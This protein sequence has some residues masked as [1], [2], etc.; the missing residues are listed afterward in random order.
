MP[1]AKCAQALPPLPAVPKTLT[2][3]I[4]DAKI[5]LQAPKPP[6]QLTFAKIECLTNYYELKLGNRCTAAYFYTVK[7]AKLEKASAKPRKS[8]PAAPRKERK[9]GMKL[10]RKIFSKL[11]RESCGDQLLAY[12]GRQRACGLKRIQ[13]DALK[14]IIDY[15]EDKW[16]LELA[17]EKVVPLNALKPGREFGLSDDLEESLLS[18]AVMM[19]HMPSLQYTPL[20]RGFYGLPGENPIPI[21]G[22]FELWA[23]YK[24]HVIP[25]SD[26]LYL[27]VNYAITAF[28]KEGELIKLLPEL[29]QQNGVPPTLSP[30]DVNDLKKKLTRCKARTTHLDRPKTFSITG[31]TNKSAAEIRFTDRE[32]RDTSV[33]QY[34]AKKY[35]K[36]RYP[37]LP[38]I[39]CG[40]DNPKFF[41]IEVIKIEKGNP[42]RGE[43]TP[44]LVS[45][46][47]KLAAI[48][49][50][51]RLEEIRAKVGK[52]RAQNELEGEFDMKVDAELQVPAR[53]LPTP[54]LMIADGRGGSKEVRVTP[55]VI[56]F[57]S[58][59]FF[60]GSKIQKWT[61]VIT[62]ERVHQRDVG[63]FAQIFRDQGAASGVELGPP[64]MKAQNQFHVIS[65]RT[66]FDIVEKSIESFV[67]QNKLEFVLFVISD[68]SPIHAAIKFTCDVKLGVSSK[69]VKTNTVRKVVTND[70][71]G[72][73]Q[74]LLNILYGLNPKFNG[75]NVVG[76]PTEFAQKLLGSC[77]IL[78]VGIDV[79]H[80]QA[81]IREGHA[82]M[83]S[84][85]GIV[86]T[87]NMNGTLYN[88]LMRAQRKPP[89]SADKEIV[90]ADILKPALRLI[91]K[92]FYANTKRKPE[93]I[94][95]YRDGV[96]T[97][98]FQAVLNKEMRAI[99][100]VCRDLQF[101]PPI[102]FITVQ[103]R[104][105]TRLFPKKVIVDNRNREKQNPIAGTVVDSVMTGN[106]V[107]N[108]FMASHEGIQGTSKPAHYTVLADE[109][110]FSNDQLQ[111]LTYYLC[112]LYG[113]CPRAV[114][115]PSPVY[116]AHHVAF[117]AAELGA[118]K[119]HSGNLSETAT[120]SSGSSGARHIEE[121]EEKLLTIYNDAS[122]VGVHYAGRMFFL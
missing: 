90:Q 71:P 117:R 28:V 21:S 11:P 122:T 32:G 61:V 29:I 46:I 84:T 6:G 58:S 101:R 116:Y 86:G 87:R 114:S 105:D 27:N 12:D 81:K 40:V 80:G 15:D 110:N 99:V 18:M 100:E 68:S 66:N 37:N 22:G 33:A 17:Y 113:K 63:N 41:P 109:N 97:G 50:R 2:F 24:P 75:E 120:H 39:Q 95:V 60:K 19:N 76:A 49:P 65:D 16:S 96:S 77:P 69:C 14:L 48:Q 67:S 115:L 98:Q 45:D 72:P 42:F 26:K 62:D 53:I 10:N 103:K 55:G 59:R 23:G 89:N 94:I 79:N 34:F 36:L 93:R 82:K 3:P 70:R 25:G 51:N 1:E 47:I 54:R 78:I 5:P 112:H 7:I 56:D 119:L 102:T 85:V 44:Q 121:D 107:W 106:K 38:C 8:G 52:I 74:C 118:F 57:R 9:L 30:R 35:T 91:M 4:V 31:V 111:S 108:F 88:A 64:L 92:G 20:G 73:D 13:D 43:Q 83:P 104:H